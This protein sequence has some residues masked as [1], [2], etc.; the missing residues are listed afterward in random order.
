[1]F[2][3]I[4]SGAA[5]GQESRGTITGTITDSNGAVVP[6]ASVTVTNP[7]TKTSTNTTTTDEG[8]YTLPF[9][10]PAVYTVTVEAAGFKRLVR[11]NIEVR[12]GDR[13]PLDLQLEI[14]AV[15]ETVTVSGESTPLIEAETATTGQVI[16]RRR[17]SE[18]PLPDGNPLNLARLA[19][20][21]NILDFTVSANQPFSNTGSSSFSVNGAPGG[22]DFTLDGAPNTNDKRVGIGNRSS[23]IPPADAVQEFKVTTSSFDAQQGHAAG[24]VIDVAIRSGTNDLHGSLYEFVRNDKLGANNF[25]TNRTASLGLDENGKARRPVRRYNRYGGTIG[26]PVFLPRF[27]EGGPAYFSGR[28]RTFFFF[29]YESIKSINPF[30]LITTVPTLAERRGDFSALLASGIR[31][32]DPLTARSVGS[33]IIRDPFPNNIIPENRI[34]PVALSLMRF[35]PLPNQPGDAQGRDNFATNTRNTN[36]YYSVIARGDHTISQRQRFFVRYSHNNR[37][38]DDENGAGAINGVRPTAVIETRRNNNGAYDHVINLTPTTILNFRVG[39][40]RFFNPETAVTVGVLEPASLNFSPRAVTQFRGATGFPRLDIPNFFELGDRS[41]VVTHTLY[42]AQPTLTKI[43]GDHTF[44]TGYDYRVYR[45]NIYPQADVVGRY[46]FRT[47]F[48]RQTDQSSTAASIGQELAAFLIGIPAANSL[49]SRPA[50]RANQNIYHGVFFQDDWKVTRRLTLNLGVRYEYELPVTERFN[51]NVRRFDTSVTNPIEAGARVAYARNPIPEIPAAAFRVPGGLVFVDENNRGFYE[52]DKNNF[53]P[54]LGFA[55]QLNDRT[56]VRGGFAI[57]NAPFTIEGM[58]QTGFFL[59]TFVVPTNDN[60]LTFA[61]N[62]TDPFPNGVNEPAG[63]GRGLATA[64]GQTLGGAVNLLAPTFDRGAYPLNLGGTRKNAQLRRFALSVQRELPGRVVVEAAYV[65]S[66]GRNLTTLND[67]NAIPRRYLSA[68]EATD[69]ATITFLETTFPNPFRGLP[70]A[71]GSGFFTAVTL[72]RQQ[73]LRPFPQ[74]L[75]VFAESYDGRSS[76]D[77]AQLR[78]EHRFSA[79]YTVLVSYTFSKFLEETTRLN[80]TDE[81]YEERIAGNDTPHR[82][83]ISGIYELPFGRGRKFGKEVSRLTDALIGGFQLT[84]N[85]QYQTGLPLTIPNLGF[86]G[87]IG[88]LRTTITSANIGDPAAG[89]RGTTFDTSLFFDRPAAR[90]NFIIRTLPT[91]A[92]GFRGDAAAIFDFSVI[93]NI[94]FTE[95]TRLQLRAEFLNALNKPFFAVPNIA[96]PRQGTFGSISETLGLPRELQLGIKLIF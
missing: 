81:E 84:G 45:E 3:I 79:G 86:R 15:N 11:S 57:Y 60:G 52:A 74:F 62:L 20:G 63:A 59:D 23:F 87:D 2:L 51:R 32:Y 43:A 82:L 70:E 14:G 7:A 18:L 37:D 56:V 17:I 64:I 24:A 71:Q 36:A 25:F 41:E 80:P 68:S 65:G 5:L 88:N 90:S 13:V 69:A 93:K 26:G 39:F 29:A 73:L 95:V 42:S 1:M 49:V 12:V 33:R 50:S 58:N 40:S 31:I 9:L 54:R 75:S 53:Q 35:F 89:V 38:E 30:S 46:R 66:R 34:N 96:D 76:Y 47:D 8:N 92:S 27:G 61:A 16:D 67:I 83:S 6:N 21:V 94:N 91:R 72:Q 85:F 48:T 78:V 19:A 22:N 55:Y 44:R 10:T 77:S 4:V 28:N